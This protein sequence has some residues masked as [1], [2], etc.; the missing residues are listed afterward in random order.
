MNAAAQT[1]A[2]ANEAHKAAWNA[3]YAAVERTVGKRAMPDAVYKVSTQTLSAEL[4]ELNKALNEAHAARNAAWDAKRA[5]DRAE[6]CQRMEVIQALPT[7]RQRLRATAD[8]PT[9]LRSLTVR[10]Y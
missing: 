1:F 8:L 3:Y 5:A 10:T 7:A 6:L 9:D 2:A 4:V